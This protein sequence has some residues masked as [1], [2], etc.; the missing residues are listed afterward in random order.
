MTTATSTTPTT[1]PEVRE[2][3]VPSALALEIE[4]S[5]GT[6][7]GEIAAAMGSAFATLMLAVH[8]HGLVVAGPPRAIYQSWDGAGT[9]ISAA[10]PIVNAPS[11]LLEPAV[12]I[13]AIP[14]QQALRF[15]HHGS[16]Q[17]IK[18]THA[19]IDAWLR[20]RGAIKTDAD[21]A[22]YTPVWEEYVSDP[23]TT[24]EQELMTYIYLPLP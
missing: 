1:A 14:E 18:D 21:W 3:T 23:T 24:P 20:E 2:V 22:R 10:M 9:R 7:P 6:G 15:T 13:A 12:M 11:D 4:M 19:R 17:T 8:S 5:V 16:Y